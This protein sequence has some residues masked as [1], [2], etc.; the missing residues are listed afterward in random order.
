MKVS[1]P[2]ARNMIKYF[3]L[4]F[5]FPP[6]SYVIPLWFLCKSHF[7]P[8]LRNGLETDLE[9]TYNGLTTDLQ[10]RHI[11]NVI[12]MKKRKRIYLIYLKL[13]LSCKKTKTWKTP[14][15]SKRL[16]AFIMYCLSENLWSFWASCLSSNQSITLYEGWNIKVKNIKKPIT[17]LTL[18]V[19]CF[20]LFFTLMSCRRL[21]MWIYFNV[22][23]MNSS[24]RISLNIMR[25]TELWK[26]D[27]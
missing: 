25:L 4:I 22:I 2:K 26:S 5:L 15:C 18:A 17:T 3:D 6:V 13:L 10:R 23:S 27:I 12:S 16:A 14:L 20:F 24:I 19:I 7:P 21:D 11:F 9:R 8:I 1:S